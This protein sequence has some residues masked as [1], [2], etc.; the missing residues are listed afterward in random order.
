MWQ[1]TIT[2]QK[3]RDHRIKQVL[4]CMR[5]G[6]VVFRDRH[7]C[8]TTSPH[9]ISAEGQFFRE[10]AVQLLEPG[11][12]LWRQICLH[13]FSRPIICVVLQF[14]LRPNFFIFDFSFNGVP[15]PKGKKIRRREEKKRFFE[16]A[17]IR[18]VEGYRH[19]YSEIASTKH[20]PEQR[21]SRLSRTRAKDGAIVPK[22]I[23]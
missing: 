4:V 18:V 13:E 10:E 6:L 5:C 3:P 12:E 20:V 16:W 1:G 7:S 9:S 21:H 17:S 23:S 15:I 14:F 19:V 22:K 8:K 2:F 11:R